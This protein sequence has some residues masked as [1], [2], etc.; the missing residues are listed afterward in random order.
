MS[1]LKA[2]II[3]AQSRHR[4]RCLGLRDER[5]SADQRGLIEGSRRLMQQEIDAL[6]RRAANN[7]ERYLSKCAGTS[8]EFDPLTGMENDN[9]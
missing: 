6:L 3:A 9:G 7:N 8:T 5:W 2:E 1:T 4:L